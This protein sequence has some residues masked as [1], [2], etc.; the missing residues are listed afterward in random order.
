[1][2]HAAVVC[3]T[4]FIRVQ[5]LSWVAAAAG[6]WV[7]PMK[8]VV[9]LCAAAAAGTVAAATRSTHRKAVEM[10]IKGLASPPG[11]DGPEEQSLHAVR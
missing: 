10:L 1:M 3:A 5:P 4:L 6:I 11:R 8:A 2:D 9:V 7:L